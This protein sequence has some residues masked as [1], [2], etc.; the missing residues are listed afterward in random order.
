MNKSEMFKSA[1]EKAK[2]AV[3]FVGDYQISF[4]FYLKE[5]Y[6][7]NKNKRKTGNNKL[8]RIFS[9]LKSFF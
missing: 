8:N 6:A 5:I 4:Q 2:E 7:L 9:K 3:K 1:H